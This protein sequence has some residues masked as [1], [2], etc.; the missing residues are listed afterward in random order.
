MSSLNK[1]LFIGRVGKDVEVRDFNDNKLATFSLAISEKGY[2]TRSGVD[3]PESTEWL[4]I[5]IWGNLAKVAEQY[6]KKGDLLY[7]EGKIRT[8]SYDD[9]NGNKRYVTEI[10]ASNM[11]MLGGKREEKPVT[12]ENGGQTQDYRNAG[13]VEQGGEDNDDDLPF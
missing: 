5:I 6:V 9:N 12:Y 3:V 4:N 2:K 7:I 8:R 1:C 10:V 11:Q 13:N